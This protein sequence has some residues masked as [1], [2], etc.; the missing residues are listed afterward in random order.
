MNIIPEERQNGPSPAPAGSSGSVRVFWLDRIET[1]GR[2]R[3]AL[4][5]LSDHYPEIERIILF[6]SLSRGD[7]VPGSDADL[8]LILRESDLPFRER[9]A[10]YRPVD[11]G[12]G[13]DVFAYTWKEMDAMKAAGN[14]FIAQALREGIELLKTASGVRENTRPQPERRPVSG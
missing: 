11:A 6:G 4:K 3:K 7:A 14:L 13:V 10:R 5:A 8:L 12:I 2:L 1:L 9:S